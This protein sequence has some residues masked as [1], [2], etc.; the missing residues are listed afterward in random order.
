MNRRPRFV[1]LPMVAI[2]ASFQNPA[3][4]DC[5]EA[6]ETEGPL[7]KGN[8]QMTSVDIK[9]VRDSVNIVN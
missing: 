3:T 9:R 2:F 8:P 6:L 4:L 5:G 1:T 7:R